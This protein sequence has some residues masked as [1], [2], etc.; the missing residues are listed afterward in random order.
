VHRNVE[1]SIFEF[2]NRYPNSALQHTHRT[3]AYIPRDIALALSQDPALI[4]RAVE[5][6]YTRD[7]IQL[8]VRPLFHSPVN[9]K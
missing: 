1:E 4:Q 6:F 5:T 8:R 3:L 7:A 2:W 9:P